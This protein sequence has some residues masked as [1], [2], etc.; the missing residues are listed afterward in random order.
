MEM[1]IDVK[2]I[3]TRFGDNIV[4]QGLNLHVNRGEIYGLLGPSGCGKTTLMKEMVLLQKYQKGSINV[5]GYELNDIGHRNAQKLRQQWGMLFQF[6]A[7]YSS[8]N[9]YDNI[10]LSL[11]E[12]TDISEALIE[13]IVSYKIDIVG[14][15]QNVK[16]QFPSQISGGMKKK[17]AL[18]R[19]LV[20]DPKLLFLDEPTSG[21]DPISA[22]E[23]DALI[24]RLR[25]RFDL[26]IVMVTHDLDS[27]E[28]T[29][30]RAAILDK[31]KVVAEGTLE[32]IMS[33]DNT[34]IKTFFKGRKR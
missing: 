25:D 24:L 22:G 32:D 8:L 18:A 27:I 5:L 31:Q 1:I 7:L 20:M 34:F 11:R 26:T 17:A 28:V 10:A 3:T 30:D 16:V 21:L 29:L 12:Y 4:H 9:I 33:I 14:L 19:A 15:E 2:N 6:G 23:F 13:E